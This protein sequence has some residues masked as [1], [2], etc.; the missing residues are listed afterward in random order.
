[1]QKRQE[2]RQEIGAFLAKHLSVHDELFS[3]PDGS[4]METYF[5]QGSDREYFVKVG[6][7]VERYLAMAEIGVTVPVLTFGQLESSGTPIIV[8]PRIKGRKPSQKD[9]WDQLE[10]VAERIRTMHNHPHI[11]RILP[12]ASSSLHKEVATLALHHLRQKWERYKAKAPDVAGFVDNSLL[13]LAEQISTFSTAGLVNSHN[14]I[15]NANW[16]FASDGEIYLLDFEAMSR[17]DPALDLGA[18]LW[19]YYPPELRGRFLDIAGYRYD[20]E[21][22]IRMQVRMAMHCFHIALPR[23]ESF[24]RFVPEHFRERLTDFKACLQ[25]KENPKG[26]GGW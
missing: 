22:K 19:W 9:Y 26:Y 3:L 25:G 24:D 1:M 18:L 11:K 8:Q 16:L 14:D 21:L 20:H 23:E 5:V 4:G 6:A 2:H 12:S 15:C 10:K 17:E 7:P 13:Q